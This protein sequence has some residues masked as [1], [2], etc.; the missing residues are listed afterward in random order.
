MFFKKTS[1]DIRK[2]VIPIFSVTELY[3]LLLQKI[4][5]DEIVLSD[6]YFS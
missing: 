3:K 5:K 2:Y 1:E 4:N 6:N